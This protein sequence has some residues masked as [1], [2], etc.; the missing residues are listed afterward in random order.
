[1]SEIRAARTAEVL[2]ALEARKGLHFT[3]TV[4]V[5]YNIFELSRG[6][7]FS[8]DMLPINALCDN[9]VEIAG[10]SENAAEVA[11]SVMALHRA[12]RA[13]AQESLK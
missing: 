4:T 7:E 11:N 8:E 3:K 1:M 6:A 12:V 9:I 10:L 13:D 2:E 5:I